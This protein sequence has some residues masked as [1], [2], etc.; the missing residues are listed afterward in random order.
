MTSQCVV[1][2]AWAEKATRIC[3]SFSEEELSRE[4]ARLGSA[5]GRNTLQTFSYLKE[6]SHGRNIEGEVH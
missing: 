3:Q 2:D 5:Q 4:K 6:G 1:R